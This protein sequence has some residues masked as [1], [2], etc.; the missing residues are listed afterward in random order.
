MLYRGESRPPEQIAQ[1]GGF[2]PRVP[3]ATNHPLEIMSHVAPNDFPED[4]FPKLWAETRYNGYY[5]I[6]YGKYVSTSAE[7]STALTYSDYDPVGYVYRMV[8]PGTGYRVRDVF[9]THFKAYRPGVDLPPIMEAEREIVFGVGGI[10]LRFV[11]EY[12]QT[13]SGFFVPGTNWLPFPH[14][15]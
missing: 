10:P 11:V 12:Q 15:E 2:F 6:H 13:F 1:A 4:Q 3:G 7:L 14:D 8:D 5:N 9:Q